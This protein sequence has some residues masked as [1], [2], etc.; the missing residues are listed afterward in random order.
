[1]PL[2]LAGVALAIVIAVSIGGV[3]DAQK[4][5]WPPGVQRVAEASP[6]L[7]PE[8]AMKTFYLPPGYHVELVASEPL[9]QDPIFMDWD[10]Q[11]RLWVIEMPAFIPDLGPK[12]DRDP[13]CD[14][15]VL[16]D[17]NNDG[18]MDKRT[19]FAD[20]LIL[21]R[22]IKIIDHGVLVAEPPNLWLMR[23]T[24]G[25]LRVDTKDLL[26]DTFGDRDASVEHNANS[27]FWA[28]D[29]WM[30]TSEHTKYYRLKNGKLEVA[31]TLPRGQWGVTQDDV[32]HIF[33][34]T[35]SQALNVDLVSTRYFLRNP[36]LARTRGMYE[37]LVDDR[38]EL[39]ATFPVRP[40]RGVNRGYQTGQLREDGTL[41]TYT[42]VS[43]PTVY[44]GDRLPG[45]LYG[46]VFLAEPSGNLVSRVILSDDGTTLRA[47]KAY[48]RAEFLASTDERFRPVWLSSA[49]DGT[50]YVVDMYR[51]II[52]YIDLVTKYLSDWVVK[53]DLQSGI[54]YG[55]IYR[56]VHDTT[57]RDRRPAL[58]TASSAT[59]VA[60][61][62]HPNGWWRD[63]AQQ[64]L[65][66]RRD[67]SAV[68]ALVKLANTA[69]LPRTR[70]QALWTLDGMDA[71]DPAIVLSALENPSRDVRVSALRLSERWLG[72]AAS[73]FVA[74]VL[75]RV[76]D[77]DQA[78]R[79]QVAATLGE[80]KPGPQK[81][82][83]IATLLIQHGDD[84]ITVDAALSGLRGS[85]SIV[86]EKL[87]QAAGR[88]QTGALDAAI[89]LLAAAIAR[90]DDE[91]AIQGLFTAVTTDE[92]VGWQRSAVVRGLEI[93]TGA[94][95]GGGRGGRGAGAA[96][97]TGPGG[98]GAPEGDR[99]FPTPGGDQNSA[100][101]FGANPPPA[102]KTIHTNREPVLVGFAARDRT[103]LGPR[104]MRI[105]DHVE[106]PGK[107][108]VARPI[109]PPLAA[110][111][112]QRFDSGHAIYTARC[113][114]CHQEDGRGQPS[115]APPLA[116]SAL[117]V[118]SAGVTT[119]I[120]LNGKE[121]AVGLMPPVGGVLT[122][123][124]IA[125]VLTYIRRQWGNAGSPIDPETAKSI[126]ALSAG[127]ARPWTEEELARIADGAVR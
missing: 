62:S 110:A 118:A 32:G 14:I 13:V 100:V 37:S 96:N 80:L 34:N 95:V 23:D 75:K 86:L 22:T 81:E 101:F 61:L 63:S 67:M 21:P 88:T 8:A 41:A 98:R 45:E 125:A 102:L 93:A 104:I 49:P 6:P 92:L 38:R 108:G 121:G 87:L 111:E 54:H 79:R 55:R 15:V 47:K 127:R 78:V 10:F 35:N 36:N 1:M 84:P 56:V 18:K 3:L 115:I 40:N 65:V 58:D 28:L 74:A 33:R 122:D 9:V 82:D 30:Y 39:N 83:A 116:G 71:L 12:H 107:P 64:L 51:G 69:P 109:A 123:D 25:D 44:R 114:G 106:W 77:Q 27:L 11:G 48:E 97:D 24:N 42:A 59:L 31:P 20:H 89:P 73:P 52:Q 29:N 72:D 112:Q 99:A 7:S 17:T 57:R 70:L 120:L 90:G 43:A 50:L 53:H 2:R 46:N 19:V 124:Q 68:P 76:A 91:P 126:R 117:A 103:D 5:T 26:T 4:S 119:R 16:E 60:T 113:Q 85:E 94:T 105:L 66:Q